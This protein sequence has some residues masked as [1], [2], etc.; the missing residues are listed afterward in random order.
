MQHVIIDETGN[1][2]TDPIPL[3]EGL[4][5]MHVAVDRGASAATVTLEV[6]PNDGA[7]WQPVATGI[8]AY[9]PTSLA[10]V[11]RFGGT[12]ARLVLAGA[13]GPAVNVWFGAHP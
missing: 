6:S 8:S 9:W 2:T 11:R 1:V 4:L 13:T 12:H 3:S 5:G 10:F 7:S